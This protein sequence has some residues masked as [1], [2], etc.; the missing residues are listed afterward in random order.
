MTSRRDCNKRTGRDCILMF[1]TMYVK[2]PHL[3]TAKY[4]RSVYRLIRDFLMFSITS[5]TV[6]IYTCPNFLVDHQSI[7]YVAHRFTFSIVVLY[8]LNFATLPTQKKWLI[9]VPVC[10]YEKPLHPCVSH[11]CIY[12]CTASAKQ[13]PLLCSSSI[14][15]G[16]LMRHPLKTFTL[17]H[18]VCLIVQLKFLSI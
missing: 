1:I 7:V 16:P 10:T 2:D 14:F 17:L 5:R 9:F 15:M 4:I 6:F 12:I 3:R 13:P 8:T 11:T 18:Y